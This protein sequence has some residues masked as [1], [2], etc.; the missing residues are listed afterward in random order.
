M[1][2]TSGLCGGAPVPV[3]V[4]ERMTELALADRDRDTV[5]DTRR[6]RALG[7]ALAR[8]ALAVSLIVSIVAILAAV[9]ASCVLA[10][11]RSDLIMM[12]ESVT[13]SFTTIGIVAVIGVVMGVLTI[14]ALRD[15]APAHSK[16]TTRRTST[17]TASRR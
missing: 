2:M 1:L 17:T 16:R 12:E 15:V 5:A 13:T 14:L 3:A 8:L 7:V 10:S 6:E 4:S 11:S 9:S